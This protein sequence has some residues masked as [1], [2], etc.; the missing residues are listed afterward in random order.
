MPL[1]NDND[2]KLQ[3][4]LQFLHGF[5]WNSNDI[6]IVRTKYGLYAINFCNYTSI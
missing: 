5:Y 6:I 4:I 1:L 2:I 3:N